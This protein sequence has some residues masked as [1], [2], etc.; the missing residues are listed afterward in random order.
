MVNFRGV[1]LGCG[2]PPNLPLEIGKTENV[3][4]INRKFAKMQFSAT[5]R[6]L[7]IGRKFS[8]DLPGSNGERKDGGH[9]HWC[10]ETKEV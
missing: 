10:G 5:S 6:R 4:I 8:H 1:G 7:D 2:L 3:A 9:C